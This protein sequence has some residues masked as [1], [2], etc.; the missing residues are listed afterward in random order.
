[1]F[2]LIFSIDN[3]ALQKVLQTLKKTTYMG[4]MSMYSRQRS[5]ALIFSLSGL[6]G[7]GG[8]EREG[9]V[10]NQM[11]GL[12]SSGVLDASELA[13]FVVVLGPSH[14]SGNRAVVC[15]FLACTSLFRSL[16]RFPANRLKRAADILGTSS[17]TRRWPSEQATED[18]ASF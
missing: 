1:M 8:G 18:T 12:L 15:F 10:T 16:T 13:P 11:G 6:R 2:A 3:E 9:A 5:E 4:I 14:D 17:S 7:S